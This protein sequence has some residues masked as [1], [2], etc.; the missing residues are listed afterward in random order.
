MLSVGVCRT[1]FFFFNIGEIFIQG[2]EWR[3]GGVGR[4]AVGWVGETLK[5]TKTLTSLQGSSCSTLE[6]SNTLHKE[7]LKELVNLAQC[8]TWGC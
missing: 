5:E 7:L 4:N 6:G 3:M 2:G 8:L 1:L